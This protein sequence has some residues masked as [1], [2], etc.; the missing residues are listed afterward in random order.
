MRTLSVSTFTH[1]QGSAPTKSFKSQ[2]ANN[3]ITPLMHMLRTVSNDISASSH[4]KSG[5]YNAMPRLSMFKKGIKIQTKET[6]HALIISIFVKCFS[7][8]SGFCIC[9]YMSDSIYGGHRV[10]CN[11]R[12]IRKMLCFTEKTWKPYEQ[13]EKRPY[14]WTSELVHDVL[15]EHWVFVHRRHI[16]RLVAGFDGRCW[17]SRRE[18]SYRMIRYMR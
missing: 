2:V 1:A 12:C 10:K 5:L 14:C 9:V 8:K 15:H 11:E 6:T 16:C 4:S 13:A 17:H 3:D 7:P 18:A